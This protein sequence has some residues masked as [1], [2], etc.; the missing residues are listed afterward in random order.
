ML[1]ITLFSRKKSGVVG[2]DIGSSSVKLVALAKRGGR[3]C[4][5]GFAVVALPEKAFTDGNIQNIEEV[6]DAINKGLRI[7]TT[8]FT[9]AVTSVSASDVITKDIQLS[10]LFFGLELEEQVRIEADQF[11]PYALDEVAL[12]FEVVGPVKGNSAFNN[13]HIVAARR[14]DV[15]TREEAIELAGLNCSIV[16]VD[17]FVVERLLSDDVSIHSDAVGMLDVGAEALTFYAIEGGKVTYHRE[18]S[19]GGHDLLMQLKNALNQPDLSLTK[20][21]H[22]DEWPEETASIVSHF[23]NSTGQQIS[24]ALQFYFSSGSQD[25][26][27]NLYVFGGLTELPGLLDQVFA[28]TGIPV[29][30]LDPFA[31]VEVAAHV[32]L[33]RFAQEKCVLVKALGL[34][35][36][37]LEDDNDLN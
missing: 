22:D 11:I 25:P 4:M 34:A 21:L 26:L 12:D 31:G 3:F 5:E 16:D 29:E 28:E 23:V 9:N 35:K 8:K 1:G 14:E 24:R 15:A 6:A 30:R 17:S 13:I 37:G 18:Q 36:R 32:N 33:Q 2:V 7:C 20:L 10:Q 27:S 19:F